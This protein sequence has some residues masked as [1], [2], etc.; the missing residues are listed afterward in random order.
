[1]TARLYV[2][3]ETRERSRRSVGEGVQ[4]RIDPERVAVRSEVDEVR[5][6][7]ALAL[8]RVAEVGVVRHEDDQTSLL[9]RDAARVRDG[10][11]GAALGGAT[12][13]EEEVDRRNLRDLLH[14]ELRMKER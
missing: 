3:G 11:V 14:L 9:V 10:A 7:V 6:V 5:R 4:H 1:M 12:R 2:P 8:P 13:T